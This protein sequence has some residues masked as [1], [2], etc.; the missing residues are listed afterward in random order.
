MVNPNILKYFLYFL[1]FVGITIC[2]YYIY[3][4]S[5]APLEKTEGFQDY[6]LFSNRTW[7]SQ[8]LSGYR[9]PFENRETWIRE[10]STWTLS[11]P[12]EFETQKKSW[13][14]GICLHLYIGNLDTTQ[15]T[16]ITNAEK[17]YQ[18]WNYVL[19]KRRHPYNQYRG[20]FAWNDVY[21]VDNENRIR[22]ADKLLTWQRAKNPWP[23]WVNIDVKELRRLNQNAAD[24]LVA[25]LYEQQLRAIQDTERNA[26]Q[27]G[28]RDAGGVDFNSKS[29]MSKV[30]DKTGDQIRNNVHPTLMN[31]KI[32]NNYLLTYVTLDATNSDAAKQYLASTPEAQNYL[33]QVGAYIQWTVMGEL[34][35]PV[36]GAVGNAA[37]ALRNVRV[38][39]GFFTKNGR[40][41][42]MNVRRFAQA[43]IIAAARRIKLAN[44][45]LKEGKM[46]G[47]IV[48]GLGTAVRGVKTAIFANPVGI[49]MGLADAILSLIP[50]SVWSKWGENDAQNQINNQIL[51]CPLGYIDGNKL[52]LEE[53]STY[54]DLLP[55]PSGFGTMEKAKSRKLACVSFDDTGQTDVQM[56]RQ[57]AWAGPANVNYNADRQLIGVALGLNFGQRVPWDFDTCF[58]D[59]PPPIQLYPIEPTY[60]TL[61]SVESMFSNVA[62]TLSNDLG[63]C[64]FFSTTFTYANNVKPTDTIQVAS[65]EIY[66]QIRNEAFITP[67]SIYNTLNT[68]NLLNS[69]EIPANLE[70]NF[71]FFYKEQSGSNAIS[72]F[73]RV[74]PADRMANSVFAR[75][76]FY[77][78]TLTGELTGL[79]K[80][81]IFG[82]R[83]AIS[84]STSSLPR[85][86][87]STDTTFY[88]TPVVETP[89]HT[90][91]LDEYRTN[92]AARIVSQ[93]GEILR[94]ETLL[95]EYN[96]S[97]TQIKSELGSVDITDPKFLDSL[98]QYL[99]EETNRI[100]GGNNATFTAGNTITFI[101]KILS[102]TIICDNLITLVCNISCI[103]K[104]R[105]AE[106]ITTSTDT[107][108]GIEFYLAN[109]SGIWKPT[110]WG[111]PNPDAKPAMA[112]NYIARTATINYTPT[113][114]YKFTKY[115]NTKC[116]DPATL[117]TQLN[118][119]KENNPNKNIKAITG[120][121]TKD[122]LNCVMQWTETDYNPSE[123]TEGPE[124][125]RQAIFTYENPNTPYPYQNGQPW[126]D[127]YQGYTE[128]TTET[129]ITQ[130]NLPQPRRGLPPEVTLAGGCRKTC[131][132]PAIMK[133]IMDRYNSD[134]T[135]NGGNTKIINI[136]KIFT[137]KE[138]RCDFVANVNTGKGLVEEQ[139][140]RAIVKVSTSGCRYTIESI[141]QKDSGTF[142]SLTEGFHSY[143][144]QESFQDLNVTP[145]PGY[146]FQSTTINSA[147]VP[148][149][150][151]GDNILGSVIGGINNTW[152]T[153]TNSGKSA[154]QRVYATIGVNTTL[155]GCP[156][157]KCSSDDI[158][159]AIA[160]KYNLDN[161]GVSRMTRILK[162]STASPT[163][164]DVFFEDSNISG[165]NRF[166]NLYRDKFNGR[167]ASDIREITAADDVSKLTTTYYPG[168]S[169]FVNMSTVFY[170]MRFTMR[171][172]PNTCKFE[173]VS[174]KLMN[175]DPPSS[176]VE[177]ISQPLFTANRS[178]ASLAVPRNTS[179]MIGCG[180]VNVCSDN[181]TLLQMT[182]LYRQ[183]NPTINLQRINRVIR[184]DRNTC[185]IE[186]QTNN[187]MTNN[188]ATMRDT[189][190]FT[191][192]PDS[193]TC[194][195]NLVKGEPDPTDGLR[196]TSNMAFGSRGLNYVPGRSIYMDNLKI[197]DTMN[198]NTA[199]LQYRTPTCAP[200][201]P[202]IQCGSANARNA[203]SNYYNLLTSSRITNMFDSANVTNTT[204]EYKVETTAGTRFE[205]TH[206]HFTYIPNS[207]CTGY[208]ATGFSNVPKANS[209]TEGWLRPE[210]T[211]CYPIACENDTMKAITS[212]YYKGLP[213]AF[214]LGEDAMTI[215][216]VRRVNSNTCEYQVRTNRYM[217]L[218]GGT[219]EPRAHKLVRLRSVGNECDTM[220]V[221]ASNIE[222]SSN[223][224]TFFMPFTCPSFDP[225]VVFTSSGVGLTNSNVLRQH[226]RSTYM[227][228]LLAAGTLQT[229]TNTF[230][231]IRGPDMNGMTI[232]RGRLL[233][234]DP[235]SRN[236]RAEYELRFNIYLFQPN[237][238]TYPNRLIAAK[239]GTLVKQDLN[240]T[241]YNSWRDNMG[242]SA[243]P[244]ETRPDGTYEVSQASFTLWQPAMHP[245]IEIA[246][247]SSDCSRPSIVKLT[248]NSPLNITFVS[249]K[250]AS[251]FS[252]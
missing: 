240:Q 9:P 18:E 245:I 49:V 226:I 150:N 165:S 126:V 128:T 161:W 163:E 74:S 238:R 108:V 94:Y 117:R 47:S 148:K 182:T 45:I 31:N 233:P 115:F 133:S 166:V 127:I 5:K 20:N 130:I 14:N 235:N 198:L 160:T 183:Q 36:L 33:E 63:L 112:F 34:A 131:T 37:T 139:R 157:T 59:P 252:S 155:E 194:V 27:Q 109:V 137:S 151:F 124:R 58:A 80:T 199:T 113:I 12:P 178:A 237:S 134:T 176:E 6:I 207:N 138:D 15:Q 231:T 28:I 142:V 213:G 85:I 43:K 55:I 188:P 21:T 152:N 53:F 122:P 56:K 218:N 88:T 3:K 13:D 114:Q 203:A 234:Q 99:Y 107:N 204:C 61:D 95:G 200:P 146:F 143:P 7:A 106:P 104:S 22:L 96:T 224:Q 196:F 216:K 174:Y 1:L 186:Y 86:F 123:N 144:T 77:I 35:G 2:I 164:C 217:Q 141:G 125:I 50:D 110:A 239:A 222:S 171:K 206:L 177:D 44:T 103:N 67:L 158:L 24:V 82:I 225:M 227:N 98:A 210:N 135:I 76:D 197:S 60:P 70:Q 140:R 191:F 89:V 168:G 190:N 220:V 145:Y 52:S 223:S 149:Y 84:S 90:M 208:I 91:F 73:L 246:F 169:G 100:S 23:T 16:S 251:V 159:K 184:K 101:D 30:A 132:D 46:A 8:Q 185:M 41:L 153:L 212:N 119:Y 25:Y 202:P 66:K 19:Y 65:N 180:E 102:A 32:N 247:P 118:Y 11:L 242:R 221:S 64:S 193:T 57:C 83:S 229:T 192:E 38:G 42:A 121:K 170:S 181:N 205:D 48:K 79:L 120:W 51:K 26:F 179:S 75:K 68:T 175:P 189:Y 78:S 172:I 62:G 54:L 97:V 244:S 249:S 147:T 116:N 81:E 39:K 29:Q 69:N 154:R 214:N 236:I 201:L 4:Y 215:D 71:D 72:S 17:F 248:D 232:V 111:R 136:K 209:L 243:P 156:T 93:T 162:I 250:E 105:G 241:D 173:P 211:S 129:G 87:L 167:Y 228:G 230:D 195:W 219:F 187:R 40:N 10:L 92:L